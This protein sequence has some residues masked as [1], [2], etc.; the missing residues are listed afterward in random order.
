MKKDAV[1]V[2]VRALVNHWYVDHLQ[3]QPLLNFL[4][5]YLDVPNIFE[6]TTLD[7]DQVHE[8][9]PVVGLAISYH[10]SLIVPAEN[11]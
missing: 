8:P 2:L 3:M 7:F 1:H 4:Y 6:G 10:W 9:L 5:E 11:C